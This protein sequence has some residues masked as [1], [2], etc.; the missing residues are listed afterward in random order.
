MCVRQTI[1]KRGHKG[2]KSTLLLVHCRHST[3]LDY[4]N[5]LDTA[6]PTTRSTPLTVDQLRAVVHNSL[7]QALLFQMSDSNPCQRAVNFQS[8]NE[9]ALAD[10]TEGWDF[11]DDAV[12]QDLVDVDC[13]LG[14]VLDLA[15]RP[16]LL[17]GSLAAAR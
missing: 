12:V 16:L 8:L 4:I 6:A 11:L 15:L 3:V 10:E 1:A 7:D 5:E 2:V 17:L 9:N 13:V 14:L